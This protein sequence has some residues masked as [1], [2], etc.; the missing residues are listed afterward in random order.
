MTGETGQA[1]LSQ[2][3]KSVKN[4]EAEQYDVIN[5]FTDEGMPELKLYSISG[6]MMG[7][8]HPLEAKSIVGSRK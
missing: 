2:S 5:F 6:T 8:M 4:M 3:R 1:A 7:R